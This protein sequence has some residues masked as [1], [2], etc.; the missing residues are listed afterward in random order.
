M[1][2]VLSHEARKARDILYLSQSCTELGWRIMGAILA[3]PKVSAPSAE[4]FTLVSFCF[5]SVIQVIARSCEQCFLEEHNIVFNY[6][7]FL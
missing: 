1:V 4:D 6:L 5:I 7:L 2:Y 3:Y